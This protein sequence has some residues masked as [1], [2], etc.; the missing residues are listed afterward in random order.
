M[1]V[2]KRLARRKKTEESSGGDAAWLNTF[3]DLMNLLLCF[4]VLLFSMSSVDEDKFEELSQSLASAFSIFSGGGS[5]IDHGYLISSGMSQLSE[6]DIYFSDM[7]KSLEEI[8][9]DNSN[10]EIDDTLKSALD[11]ILDEMKEQSEEMYDNIS[12][13]T[14]ELDLSDALEI[15]IDPEYQ[16]IQLSLRGS[17]LFDSGKSDIKKEAKPVMGKIGDILKVYD[18][19]QIEI[20]GHTDSVPISS[21]TYMNNNWLSSARA[22]NAAEFFINEKGINPGMLKYSGRGEYEPVTSNATDAGR[23][24]NRRI[25]IKIY[26]ELSSKTTK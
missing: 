19:F 7:G 21:S 13:M 25:E 20:E 9:D 2:V 11:K 5:A 1:M 12:G 26:N 23:A 22:L 16:Y 18:G 6:L 14:E 24:T 15:G 8:L 17:I 4:F 3:A 10:E